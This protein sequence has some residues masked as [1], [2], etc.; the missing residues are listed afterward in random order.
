MNS[1]PL[2]VQG[3]VVTVSNRDSSLHRAI[4]SGNS[5]A[6]RAALAGGADVNQTNDAGQTP[7][8]LAI[9]AGQHQCLRPLLRAGADPWLRDHTGLTAIDWATRKGETQLAQSLSTQSHSEEIDN[10]SNTAR[11]PVREQKTPPAPVED[12]P[13]THLSPD[14]KARRFIAGLKQRLDEKAGGEPKNQPTVSEEKQPVDFEKM[15]QS[16]SEAVKSGPSTP[17]PRTEASPVIPKKTASPKI[18]GAGEKTTADQ[19]KAAG[20]QTTRQT[21]SKASETVTPDMAT[22]VGVGE[23]PT[24]SIDDQH[25]STREQTN[26]PKYTK[27]AELPRKIIAPQVVAKV[28]V[29]ADTQ[30]F[31]SPSP[32]PKTTRSSSK[33]KRCPQCG[34]IYNSD[35]L[36]YCSYDAVALVDEGAP[37]VTHRS[38]NSSPMLWIL[39][40][41]VAV[42]GAIAGLFVTERLLRRPNGQAPTVS[43]PQPPAS[44]KGVPVL[45]GQLEGKEISLPE[46]EVPANTVKEPTSVMVRVRVDRA[47]RVYSADSTE[48][49]E[50]LREASI[51]AARKSSF[52]VE[53]LGG[54]GAQGIITYT[55]K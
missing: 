46:A 43:G 11:P 52:S 15:L 13:R 10:P 42:L 53:K 18:P 29:A 34:T 12:T 49:E 45:R 32:Q 30:P 26:R 41:I 31:A 16:I 37:I 55:F 35:L 25:T 21:Y 3:I 23:K 39:V 19:Q 27:S 7:L 54:R 5:E 1:P 28:D 8:I 2:V 24:S 38:S 48:D 22:K 40:V 14:E 20:E 6:V 4:K 33:R 9:V 44:Q 17:E 51:V 50:V 47:G 36:A